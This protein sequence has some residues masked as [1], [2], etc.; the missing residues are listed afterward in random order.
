[1]T[2]D[3]AITMNRS[4]IL[5]LSVL[6]LTYPKPKNEWNVDVTA[7]ICTLLHLGFLPVNSM[8]RTLMFYCN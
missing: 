1:M 2:S 8:A 5:I 6:E 4:Q 7:V 3:H